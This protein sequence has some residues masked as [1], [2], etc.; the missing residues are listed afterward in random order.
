[1]PAFAW[2]AMRQAQEAL[3]HGRLDEAL[4]I[5]S[6]PHAQDR[7]GA[8]ALIGKLAQAFVERRRT[9]CEKDDADALGAICFTPSICKHGRKAQLSSATP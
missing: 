8:A 4:R 9:L 6:Q 7:R 3:E 5:I 2:L 1:M